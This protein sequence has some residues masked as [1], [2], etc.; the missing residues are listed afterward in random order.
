[1]E[2]ADAI[3]KALKALGIRVKVDTDETKRP[4]FKFAEYELVGIPVRIGIGAR[5]LAIGKVEVA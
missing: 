3:S 1:M 2:A 5:D 4:G